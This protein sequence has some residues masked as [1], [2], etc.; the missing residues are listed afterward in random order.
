MLLTFTSSFCW[1]CSAFARVSA[2][3]CHGSE[4]VELVTEGFKAGYN[5]KYSSVTTGYGHR[6]QYYLF[7][8]GLPFFT[9]TSIFV[10]FTQHVSL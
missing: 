3:F 5:H 1:S 4:Q 10:C 7:G 8:S 9:F 6:Y 2:M